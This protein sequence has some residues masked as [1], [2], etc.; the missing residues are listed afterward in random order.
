MGKT[1]LDLTFRFAGREDCAL[2]LDFIRSLAVY[3]KMEDDVVATEGLLDEWL[4]D[5]KAAEV[6]FAVLDGREIGFALFFPNYSTF[7][8]RAGLYLEDI[9]VLPEYRGRGAGTAML[10]E[11]AKIAAG[12]GYGRFELS[13]LDW[14][15]PS[16][17]FY[18]SLG[19]RAMDDWTVYRFSGESLEKLA[20]DP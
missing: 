17:N 10:R 20:G 11:L 14:N 8:G 1:P 15:A 6:L 5:K 12:R 9:F 19:A 16:I 13:C 3:E 2:I 4:F 18:L 7:L